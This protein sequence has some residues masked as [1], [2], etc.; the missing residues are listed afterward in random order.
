MLHRLAQQP[1]L[2]VSMPIPSDKPWMRIQIFSQNEER[3]WENVLW[4]TADEPLPGGFD[5]KANATTVYGNMSDAFSNPLQVGFA[6]TLG[7]KVAVNNGVYTTVN[8]VISTNGGEEVSAEIP[9]EACVIVQAQCEVAGPSGKG[10]LFISG[11]CS[12]NISV[13][14]L[15]TAGAALYQQIPDLLNAVV[16]GNAGVSWR[17][18]IFSRHNNALQRVKF[19]ELSDVLCH[20]K[21]RRPAF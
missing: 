11:V 10:R 15:S 5:A 13:S 18:C 17:S 12:D 16:V 7:A 3:E 20:R 21:K 8:D 19:W 14:R 9:T 4:F 2:G 6:E 1:L